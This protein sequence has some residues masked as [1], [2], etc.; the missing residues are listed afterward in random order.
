MLLFI[1]DVTI[2]IKKVLNIFKKNDEYIEKMFYSYLYLTNVLFFMMLLLQSL[3]NV[4]H[5]GQNC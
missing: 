3:T 4:R 5:C 2:A 1:K